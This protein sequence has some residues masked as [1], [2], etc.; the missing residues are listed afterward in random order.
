M[1]RTI[2]ANFAL[3]EDNA[4]AGDLRGSDLDA[5]EDDYANL[6]RNRTGFANVIYRPRTY[7]L[8]SAE[9]RNIHSWPIEGYAHSNQSLGLAAGYLF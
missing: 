3:G 6:A 1:T 5:E 8:F 7:L 2:E 9:Y 4:Y